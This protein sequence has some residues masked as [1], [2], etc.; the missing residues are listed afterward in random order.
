SVECQRCHK[1]GHR[2]NVCPMKDLECSNC[3]KR[4]HEERNCR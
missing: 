4:G 1:K 2:A 3:H